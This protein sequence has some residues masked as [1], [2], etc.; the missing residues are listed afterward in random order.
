VVPGLIPV[1]PDGDKV[2]RARAASIYVE[3]GNVYL[4]TPGG[5]YE[6]QRTRYWRGVAA[7]PRS[8]LPLDAVV[9][10]WVSAFVDQWSVFP[11]GANDDDVDAGSQAI[12]RLAANG[13][14]MGRLRRLEIDEAGLTEAATAAAARY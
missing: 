10:A 8:W 2:A 13:D 4:P 12:R 3:S 7:T 9:S 5:G 6:A 11:K 1:E 14:V